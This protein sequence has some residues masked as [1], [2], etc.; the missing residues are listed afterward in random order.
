MAIQKIFKEGY[1]G[2][3]NNKVSR[4]EELSL[5]L[6][7]AFV[8]D[9]SETDWVGGL[10][11]PEGLL[12][13]MVSLSDKSQ[14]FQA[15]I[16]LYENYRQLSLVVAS[17]K[18]FWIYLGHADLYLYMHKRFLN[19]VTRLLHKDPTKPSVI[20]NRWFFPR[21]FV[22]NHLAGMWWD[23]NCTIDETNSDPYINTRTLFKYYDMRSINFANFKMFRNK[24]QV[25]GILKCIGEHPEIFDIY[26]QN[27]VRYVT[28]YFN[29]L[30]ATK[31]LIA[32]PW[33]F[34]YNTVDSLLDEV[35][36]V[37][38]SGKETIIDTRTEK[39]KQL[40]TDWQ[41]EQD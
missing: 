38:D 18:S 2:A 11:Q 32:L 40:D 34:F 20:L 10:V 14:D 19:D 39:E 22:R 7:K 36:Q 25:K 9:E 5:Y 23:V 17:E 33:E 31:Q 1:A 16:T 27:R 24:E 35:N 30:G 37:F 6:N 12:D 3:L 29:R 15:A 21:E 41:N 4:G 26:S 8:Y 28:K 13:K